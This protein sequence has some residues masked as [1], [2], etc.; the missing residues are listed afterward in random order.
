MISLDNEILFLWYDDYMSYWKKI[1]T[2]QILKNP[3]LNVFEDE[4]LLPNGSKSTY[5]HFGPARDS[6]QVIAIRKDGKILVQKEYSYPLDEWIYQF[7]GGGL[8]INENPLQGAVR[9]LSEEANLSGKLKQIGWFYPNNR[10]EKG[11]SYVFIAKDIINFPGIPDDEEIFID[12]WLSVKE[13]GELIKSG[14]LVNYSALS[15]W[16]IYKEVTSKT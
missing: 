5:V 4:I 12:Y 7:P 13:I 9:E 14:K 8:K 3:R 10:R 11:K 15:A 6:S 16:A 1:S 2:K